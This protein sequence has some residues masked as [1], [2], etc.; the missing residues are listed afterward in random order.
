MIFHTDAH[1]LDASAE[2]VSLEGE[3]AHSERGGASRTREDFLWQTTR[4]VWA[5]SRPRFLYGH[6]SPDGSRLVGRTG[7]EANIG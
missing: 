5:K 6:L 2:G 7:V 1:V 4:R 3:T